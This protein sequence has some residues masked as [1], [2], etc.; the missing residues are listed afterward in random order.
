M[1]DEAAAFATLARPVQTR[2]DAALAAGDGLFD[3]LPPERRPYR[4]RSCRLAHKRRPGRSAA[5]FTKCE[6]SSPVCEAD[7]ASPYGASSLS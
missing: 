4:I 6:R 7:A 5:G 2:F 3:G 1:P